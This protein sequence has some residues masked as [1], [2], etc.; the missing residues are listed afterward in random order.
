MLN[1][2]ILKVVLKSYCVLKYPR[3]DVKMPQGVE[4]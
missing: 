2:A 3:E 4:N 1:I